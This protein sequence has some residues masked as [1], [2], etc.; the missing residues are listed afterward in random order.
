[1]QSRGRRGKKERSGHSQRKKERGGE[2]LPE[3]VTELVHQGEETPEER[4][5]LI[6]DIEA[7]N[8][9]Y[10]TLF[11]EEPFMKYMVGGKIYDEILTKQELLIKLIGMIKVLN[12]N[13]ETKK[14]REN[15]SKLKRI[16]ELIEN[17]EELLKK[18]EKKSN[19]SCEIKEEVEKL[20]DDEV[21]IIEGNKE[22]GLIFEKKELEVQME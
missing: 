7:Q 18:M 3:Y 2:K 8:Y 12:L 11:G 17:P 6:L 16:K 9:A 14:G 1:M 19:K 5:L 21:L 22:Q 10:Y 4:A 13:K 20:G 15:V